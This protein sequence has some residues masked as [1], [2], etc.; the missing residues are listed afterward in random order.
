MDDGVRVVRTRLLLPPGVQ[1]E[2][3]PDSKWVQIIIMSATEA[4]L[5]DCEARLLSVERIDGDG[6]VLASILGEPQFC[7]WSNMPDGGNLR[8]TIPAHV[9]QAANIFSVHDGS[10][11]LN[12][13]TRAL[14]Y[15][16][17]DAIQEPGRY[18]LRIGV[19]AQGCP[20]MLQNFLFEWNGAY[21]NIRF[22]AEQPDGA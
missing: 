17:M 11:A 9:P 8:M 13:E 6:N 1:P 21:G 10:T 22:S 20:T 4:A 19:S 12:V 7:T 18:R 5:V 3:G 16:Y 14:K 2:W 15:E